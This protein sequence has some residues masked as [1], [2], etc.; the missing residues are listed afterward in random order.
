MKVYIGNKLIEDQ[1]FKSITDIDMLKY[2]A[3][4]GECTAIVIDGNLR[5]MTLGEV[6]QA[7]ALAVQKLRIDGDLIISD[8]DFDL[9][10]Y[11]Y[12]RNPN[13]LDLNN[14]AAN[15]GGFKSFLTHDLVS[16]M[17]SNYKNLNLNSVELSNIEF[18][19]GYTKKP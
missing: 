15:A 16:Q 8:I 3:D 12:K 7:V 10:S 5:K 6:N 18:K 1:S 11:V 2:I 13:I 17:I 14:M 4:D 9:L 19:L